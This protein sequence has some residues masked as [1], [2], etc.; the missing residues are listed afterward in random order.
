L[1]KLL[2]ER[3][4]CRTTETYIHH[5]ISCT[6]TLIYSLPFR[7]NIHN[8]F[9]QLLNPQECLCSLSVGSKREMDAETR[10]RFFDHF[11]TYSGHPIL[12]KRKSMIFRIYS[13]IAFIIGYACW[14]AEYIETFRHLGDIAKMQDAARIAIPLSSCYGMDLYVRWGH[15]VRGTRDIRYGMIRKISANRKSTANIMITSER[16]KFWRL[17]SVCIIIYFNCKLVFARWQCCYKKTQHTNNTR[18]TKY[19]KQ[20]NDQ[21]KHST[22]NYT[23]NKHPTQNENTTITTTII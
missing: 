20:H 12:H 18:H 2:H 17:V 8:E 11:F 10:F 15:L 16:V 7:W 19:T 9:V 4:V 14:I 22:Q 5:V 13:V 3:V 6:S 21:T 1:F 23:H